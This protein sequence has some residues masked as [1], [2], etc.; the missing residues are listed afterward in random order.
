MFNEVGARL[1][2][3]S[4]LKGVGKATLAKVLEQSNA[5][6]F[7]VD[8]LAAANPRLQK[9]LGPTGAWEAAEAAAHYQIDAAS[10]ASARIVFKLDPA[11]PDL[12]RATADAP[13]FIYLKGE[14]SAKPLRSVAVI[15]TRTPTP[16]G[17]EVTTRITR[18]FA[19]DGWS[20]VS[21]LAIGCDAIAHQTA[22]ESEGHTI[23]VVAHGL[24]TI[25]PRQHEQLAARILET[26]GALI[27][28][29]GFGVEPM[30]HQFVE[31]DRIQAGL[32]KGVVMVQSDLEG[33]S[34]HASRAALR[35]GRLLAAPAPTS[36]DLHNQEPSVTANMT[37]ANSGQAAKMKLL[38]C[39]A[40]ALERLMVLR[41]RQDYTVLAE[42]LQQL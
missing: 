5:G 37:L 36:R 42:R 16:H 2:T 33:G 30:P 20:I 39:D 32:A 1:F 11:Y 7:S 40:P 18:F 6:V 27:S 34:L 28:E 24:Q 9:A 25:A 23:A 10:R 38:N 4:H 12:L 21:G 41:S 3:M 26:G 14:L 15:G 13:L 22:I 29:Y 35:Y 8:A 19:E 31:R 17:G